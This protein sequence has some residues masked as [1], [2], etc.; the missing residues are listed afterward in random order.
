MSQQNTEPIDANLIGELLDDF[1]GTMERIE[2]RA[3]EMMNASITEWER[4]LCRQEGIMTKMMRN[5]KGHLDFGQ[6][7]LHHRF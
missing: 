5:G 3:E 2:E 4:K 6:F 7:L 1:E